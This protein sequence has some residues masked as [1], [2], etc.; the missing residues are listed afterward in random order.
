VARDRNAGCRRLRRPGERTP[1]FALARIGRLEQR[2]LPARENLG[3]WVVVPARP[4]P[5]LE[6]PQ[7]VWVAIE[8]VE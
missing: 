6:A 7:A 5:Q 4:Y 2:F 1:P 8:L 3:G